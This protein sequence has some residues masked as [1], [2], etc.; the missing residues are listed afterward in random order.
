MVRSL[1]PTE[2]KMT[3]STKF[4][5][6]AI[7]LAAATA[8]ANAQ[9]TSHTQAS[10]GASQY[11]PGQEQ[12]TPGGARELSPGDRMND[13]RTTTGRSS[14]NGASENS[15]GDRMNDKR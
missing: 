4:A 7:A 12:K 5:L 8:F 6:S 14:S 1:Q 3:I 11:A 2:E 13:T 9:T 15:P 10:P